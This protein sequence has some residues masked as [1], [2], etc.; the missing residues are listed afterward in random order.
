MCFSIT[1]VCDVEAGLSDVVLDVHVGVVLGEQLARLALPPVRRRVQGRPAVVVLHVHRSAHLDHQAAKGIKKVRLHK[2]T[3]LS[4]L[5]IPFY[6]EVL[7]LSLHR[8]IHLHADQHIL[9]LH[10]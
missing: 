9:T 1:W 10:L 8:V 7:N 2:V 6:V 4:A 5:F 3:L